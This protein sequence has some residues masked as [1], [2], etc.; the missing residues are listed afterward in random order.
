MDVYQSPAKRFKK[1]AQHTTE[2]DTVHMMTPIINRIQNQTNLTPLLNM[3][4]LTTNR[5]KSN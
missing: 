2:S 4:H 1:N 5:L 3:T